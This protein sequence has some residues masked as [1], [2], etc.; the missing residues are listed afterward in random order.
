VLEAPLATGAESGTAP[1]AGGAAAGVAVSGAVEDGGA[2]A[3][4]QDWSTAAPSI[5]VTHKAGILKRLDETGMMVTLPK[6]SSGKR[7]L[8]Q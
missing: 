1:A 5:R 4:P 6:S 3:W 7:N 8:P 2:G